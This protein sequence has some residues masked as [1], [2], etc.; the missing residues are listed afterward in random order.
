MYNLLLYGYGNPGR[1]DDGL[2]I[3]LAE[4]INA[5]AKERFPGK[6]EVDT[7]YQL[8]IED[9][10]K[11]SHYQMVVFA[12]ASQESIESFTFTPVA[13]SKATIEFTM[14]AMSP[15]YIIYLC[16]DLFK[17]QPECFLLHIKGYEWEMK[18][19][20]SDDAKINLQSSL[21]FLKGKIE[22]VL[23]NTKNR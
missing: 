3:A 1:Q 9:A 18:E 19:G 4:E 15:S 16:Q 11:I 20:L 6:V 14:H 21:R 13:P 17:K 2:G 5:W 22:A 8:N 12:D 23:S 7:N 10:E